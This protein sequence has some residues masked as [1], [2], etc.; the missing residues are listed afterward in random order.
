[1]AILLTLGLAVSGV[2][3]AAMTMDH[4]GA[5][6]SALASQASDTGMADH[7]EGDDHPPASHH[8]DSAACSVFCTGVSPILSNGLAQHA[9]RPLR[10]MIEDVNR[11]GQMHLPPERPPR[12]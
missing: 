12:A 4:N 9:S 7:V 8:T 10:F 11:Q 6:P 1:M 3:N 2:A 5:G